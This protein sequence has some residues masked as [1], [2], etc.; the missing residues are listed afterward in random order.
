[1]HVFRE[2]LVVD[3][4]ERRNVGDPDAATM[5][6]RDQLAVSRMDAQVVHGNRGQAGHEPLP[7]LSHVRRHVRADIRTKEKQILIGEIL[8]DHMDVIGTAGRKIRRDGCERLPEVGGH[9]DVWLVVAVA[10]VSFLT[11]E[12]AKYTLLL[13]PPATVKRERLL[14]GDFIVDRGIT[15]YNA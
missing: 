10:M 3:L 7:R 6:G 4:L 8:T 11:F 5:R 14:Q 12:K 13:H 2:H 9:E 15:P 1:M